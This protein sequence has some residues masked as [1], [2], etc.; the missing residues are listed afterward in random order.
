[1]KKVL[2][3]VILAFGS[4]SFGQITMS[5]SSFYEVLLRNH[6]LAKQA[7]LVPLF[8]E[9]YV[10]K[11]KGSFDPKAYNQTEQKY[12]SGSQYYS[13]I[14]SGLKVPTWFG[15]ELKSGFESNRGTYLSSQDKTPTNGLWYGGVAINLGQGLLIDQRRAEL[16][17]ANIYQNSSIYE[18]QL[19]L[20]ELVYEAGYSYWSWFMAHYSYEV[21]Q[22]AMVL[23]QTRLE[24][25]SRMA[26]LGD[27]PAIDTV[28]AK[29]QVQSRE[30]M[31]RQLEADL[32][33]G[34][35]KLDTYLWSE[36]GDP[37][38]LDSLTMPNPN[39]NLK[40]QSKSDFNTLL[41]DSVISN[42][43]Y[44]KIANFKIETL[45]VEKRLKK[46]MLKPQL[47][48]QY[49][50]LNEPIN[51]NPF[52]AVSF[53]NYKWG[54]SFEMPLFLRKERGDLAL[55]DLKVKDAT[56]QMDNSLASINYKIQSS[57]VDLENSKEQLEI[58]QKTVLDT[59]ALLDA[60]RNMFS[61]GESSLFLINARET[62]YIQAKL[63]FI[64]LLAKNQQAVI[65]LK[66]A[67]AKLI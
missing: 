18:Q 27:R 12:Y 14:N 9:S 34:R 61:N 38:V 25:I 65:A 62:A 64:E 50:L 16:F 8:G 1:M 40:I 35:L 26:E 59:K 10:L 13:L 17:K 67:L 45:E 20:N 42:H 32:Q 54:V 29:I 60:E 22:E 63:K 24:A 31:L 56:F 53:N 23:A 51:Y 7:N 21:L 5:D 44:L 41:V 47:N 37:L 30:S 6:P 55:A 48:L 33:K 15:I 19:Q 39:T 58:Y 57:L 4:F 52:D 28:E 66:F 11:A 2:I 3:I 46:E 43:P 36:T 49:N